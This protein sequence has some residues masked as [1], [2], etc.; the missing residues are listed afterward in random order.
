MGVRVKP[1]DIPVKSHSREIAKLVQ[2]FQEGDGKFDARSKK[3]EIERVKEL[4][5]LTR[6]KKQQSPPPPQG[7][8]QAQKS[9]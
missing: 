5:R 6:L 7:P 1:K 4:S 2:T 9:L 3:K 8:P